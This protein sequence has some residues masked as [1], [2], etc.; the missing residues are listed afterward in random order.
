MSFNSPKDKGK[1]IVSTDESSS[2]DLSNSDSSSSSSSAS[3]DSEDDEPITQEYLDS[4]LEKARQNIIAK[5]GEGNVGQ[6]KEDVLVLESTSQPPIP[7]LNPGK[8]PPSHFSHESSSNDPSIITYVEPAMASSFSFRPPEFHHGKTLTK[9]QKKELKNKTAGPDWFDLPAP[10]EA[11]LPRLYREVEALRLRNQLDPKR[12]YRKEEGE[13]KG[14]K[15]L[16]KHFAIGKIVTT[17]TPFGGA[18][19]DN[20]TRVER[21]RTLV[22]EL[23]DDAEMKRYAKKKFEDLQR[24][25]GARG[26]NSLANKKRKPKW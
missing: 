18:S 24:V 21:K 26:R 1:A 13:G 11:D 9:K 6:S 19:S 15:G 20:L 4:L 2:S 7:S 10:A 5:A 25:R 17:E 14:I 23:V 3:S 12:F 8:L 16:P 22:D